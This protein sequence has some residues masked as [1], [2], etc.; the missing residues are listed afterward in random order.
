MKRFYTWLFI[1]LLFGLLCLLGASFAKKDSALP[2]T[3][4][5]SKS[6]VDIDLTTMKS[7]M[8]YATVYDMMSNPDKYMGKIMRMNGLY[9]R[10]YDTQ[11]DKYYH[12]VVIEDA[13]ACCQQGME[14]IYSDLKS[15]QDYPTVG[16]KIVVVGVFGSY[17]EL[18]MSYFYIEAKE[19]VGGRL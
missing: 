6:G 2:T 1:A 15:P 19:V 3:N 10:S 8:V 4:P 7:T 17:E 13:T 11:T 12:Y 14:F 16:K 5:S 18:G 9:D